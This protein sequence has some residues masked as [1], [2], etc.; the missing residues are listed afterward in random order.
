MQKMIDLTK[1]ELL[2]RI[3][4]LYNAL[5][6]KSEK[7]NAAFIVDKINQYYFTGTMQD[8]VFVLHGDGADVSNAYIETEIMPVAMLERLCKHVKIENLLPLD[9]AISCVMAVKSVYEI[10]CMAESGRQHKHL[11]EV[12]APTL[13][14]MLPEM[15]GQLNEAEFTSVLYEKM[16]KQGYHGVS[17]FGMFQTECVIGQIAFGENSLRPTNF[18]GPGGMKGLCPAVPIIGDRRRLLKKGD[19]VFVDIG[20]GFDGYHT[21]RTQIYMYD[22]KPSDEV[23]Q[24]HQRCMKV[25]NEVAAML[26]PGAI[27]AEIYKKITAVGFVNRNVK[28]FGA[29]RR[30]AN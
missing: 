13:L 22:A 30:S 12:V 19:L 4:K 25:Q 28:L 1:Q 27:P 23:M 21:D 7:W 2:T 20:Y 29:R 18:D 9:R 14:R 5:N 3:E 24:V 10:S 11:L 8:G 16:V 17:R 6:S 26:K 15:Q